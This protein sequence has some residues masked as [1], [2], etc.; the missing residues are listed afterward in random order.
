MVSLGV[1]KVFDIYLDYK[2]EHL[3]GFIKVVHSA[4]SRKAKLPTYH[5]YFENLR[6]PSPPRPSDLDLE[7]HKVACKG[8]PTAG[9][10]EVKHLL[11]DNSTNLMNSRMDSCHEGRS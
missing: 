3:S 9:P 4:K 6:E 5:C 7:T 10:P 2:R 1:P 11:S 8:P